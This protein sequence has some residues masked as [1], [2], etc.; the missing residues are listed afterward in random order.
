MF[1]S[2]H[3]KRL[4]SW[5]LQ[6]RT[7]VLDM[8]GCEI[9]LRERVRARRPASTAGNRRRGRAPSSLAGRPCKGSAYVPRTRS[10][11]FPTSK[12]GTCVGTSE[13]PQA[14]L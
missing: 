7:S 13:P 1:L 10:L 5:D 8:C 9:Q 2:V 3:D 12:T 6:K 14:L 4:G 11:H